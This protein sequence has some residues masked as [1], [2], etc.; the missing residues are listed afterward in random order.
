MCMITTKVLTIIFKS[1]KCQSSTTLVVQWWWVAF[2]LVRKKERTA[3]ILPLDYISTP[4][5]NV[6]YIFHKVGYYLY[7]NTIMSHNVI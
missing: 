2:K 6:S 1:F 3:N 7:I 4:R 5:K